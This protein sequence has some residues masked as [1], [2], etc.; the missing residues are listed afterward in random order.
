MP[1]PNN[2]LSDSTPFFKTEAFDRYFDLNLLLIN[3]ISAP[4]MQM[5]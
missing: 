1:K 4:L 5:K 2:E 3:I